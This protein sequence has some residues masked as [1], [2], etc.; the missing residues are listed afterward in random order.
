VQQQV[1]ASH[2]FTL[3]QT[4]KP[5]KERNH[6]DPVVALAEAAKCELTVK[7]KQLAGAAKAIFTKKRV[8]DAVGG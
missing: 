5:Q 3:A 6:I 1:A 8:K 4:K 2:G 7:D